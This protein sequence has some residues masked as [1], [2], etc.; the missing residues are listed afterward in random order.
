V[1]RLY[2]R[3]C[4]YELTPLFQGEVT[5]A[6]CPECGSLADKRRSLVE[7]KWWWRRPAILSTAMGAVPGL[8]ASVV[9]TIDRAPPVYG[10]MFLL[11]IAIPIGTMISF[12]AALCLFPDDVAGHANFGRLLPFVI[13]VSV[14]SFF[15][16]FS[17]V[18]VWPF[19]VMYFSLL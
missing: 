10:F 13:A 18:V 17:L 6:P 14:C 5:K 9:A 15:V 11:L 4:G 3:K 8:F 16:N 2:C 1:R 7:L 19:V 12:V